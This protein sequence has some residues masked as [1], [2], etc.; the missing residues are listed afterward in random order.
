M[1]SRRGLIT[2]LASLLAAPAIVRAES[3]MPIKSVP[4]EWVRA[5]TWVWEG[6]PGGIISVHFKIVHLSDGERAEMQAAQM[7]A[8][9]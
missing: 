4:A 6:T 5:A 9:R 7:A 3:L 2:G 1:L 8:I